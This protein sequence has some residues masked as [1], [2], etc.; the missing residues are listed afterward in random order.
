MNCQNCKQDIPKGARFCPE[1]GIEVRKACPNPNCTC[2]D[3]PEEALFCPECGT[4][5]EINIEEIKRK[6]IQENELIQKQKKK[7]RIRKIIVL[8]GSALIGVG[9]IIGLFFWIKD[10]S[11]KRMNRRVEAEIISEGNI[12]IKSNYPFPMVI[13]DGGQFEMGNLHGDDD[14]KP[15]H[16]V[17]VSTFKM[18]KTE[19]T[20]AQWQA[21]MEYN[22]SHFRGANRPV[23]S[24]SWNEVQAFVKKLNQLTGFQYRLP[25]EAEWEYAAGGGE[26][27][28]TVYAGCD[29]E[30]ALD[31]YGWFNENSNYKTHSVETK[32]PNQLG[33]YDMSGNVDEWCLDK[34]WDDFYS[35][36][37]YYPK[38]HSPND[39]VNNYVPYDESVKYIFRGGNIY[40]NSNPCRVTNRQS[41]FSDLGSNNLGFRLVLSSALNQGAFNT[42]A[43][44]STAVE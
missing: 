41:Y 13:V 18:G 42:Q 15:V 12:F 7:K 8:S 38:D 20:Q 32:R 40:Q 28:R 27:D 9:L 6:R 22:P 2:E 23:E 30:G 43:A 44:D 26:N 19:V 25:T 35:R 14:E 10:I 4:N 24:V 3:I 17:R 11:E 1:C 36:V 21:V 37:K 34:Y 33:L 29:T 16:T 31:L 5:R 39:P